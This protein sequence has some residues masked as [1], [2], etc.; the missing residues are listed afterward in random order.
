MGRAILLLA[1]AAALLVP[2]GSWGA[3]SGS[4]DLVL[5]ADRK[6]TSAE[7]TRSIAIITLRAQL[8]GGVGIRVVQRGAGEIVVHIASIS[9][10]GRAKVLLA[11]RGHLAFYDL[12]AALAGRSINASGV[13]VAAR[14]PPKSTKRTVVLRCGNG[15]P[16]CPGASGSPARRWFFYLVQGRPAMTA[17][18]IVRS[19][20]RADVDPQTGQPV[21]LMQF[22]PTGVDTFQGITAAEARRGKALWVR[23]GRPSGTPDYFQHFAIVLDRRIITWPSIDFQQYPSGISG[24]NGAQIVGLRGR[25]D[26]KGLALLMRTGTLPVGFTVQ[27]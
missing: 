10:P 2:A 11:S 6:P 15:S 23:A 16:S 27:R 9:D 21:V 26:A 13:P 4:L 7:L 22:T 25:A 17:A 8:L 1:C 3:A 18:G 24:G 12:E 19:K 20:T 5:R 14:K